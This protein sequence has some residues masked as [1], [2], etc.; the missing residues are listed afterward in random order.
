MSGHELVRR[1]SSQAVSWR[2][3][4]ALRQV[5]SETRLEQATMRAIS[6]VSEYAISEVEYLKRL[7]N[8]VEHSNP[9]AAD[10]VAAIVN[11]TVVGLAR[12]VGRFT[13]EI[14]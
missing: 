2:D 7:Q 12:R 10:A 13:S 4:R 1:A 9:D 3:V 14:G 6:A 8:Q 5:T 11:M